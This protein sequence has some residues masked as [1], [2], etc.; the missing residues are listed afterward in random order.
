MKETTKE[1]TPEQI[2]KRLA[3]LP[4]EQRKAELQKIAEEMGAKP[5]E[6]QVTFS[7]EQFTRFMSG[8][9]EET[10]KV[11]AEKATE[12]E[13]KHP[14]VSRTEAEGMVDNEISKYL[15]QKNLR[16]KE[17]EII[18]KR[19]ASLIRSMQG[20]ARPGDYDKALELEVD[21]MKRHYGH[22]HR[23]MTLGD[24][25]TGGY[26]APE[27]W[28]TR[29]YQNLAVT[30]MAR[31]YCEL[32]DMTG[33]ELLR[34]P[35]L[36]GGLTA[37]TTGEGVAGTTSQITTDQF[38]LQ[39]KKITVISKPF[40]IELLEAGEPNLIELLTRDAV[41]AF[42]RKED[43]IVFNGTN[44]SEFTGLLEQTTNVVYLGGSST[45]G[46]TSY[47]NITHDD[48]F[49]LQN[50]LDE[51]YM[52]DEDTQGSGGVT[53]EAA[54]WLHRSVITELRKLKGN[55]Q[56]Y[57]DIQSMARE[58]RLGGFPFHRVKDLRAS[59]TADTKFGVFGNLKNVWV[60]YR[61]GIRT[62]MLRE[63]QVDGQNLATTSTM[64]LRF[65]EFWDHDVIDDE[66]LAIL[67]T[68]AS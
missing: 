42:G 47:V 10:K 65:N 68:A 19:F 45:S 41:R 44:D 13:R 35:K 17:N 63:G 46:N 26:L 62:D 55:D 67:S 9:T 12:V 18:G 49:N 5:A 59:T 3:E 53:G 28:E 24:D 36:T 51:E 31:K 48:I 25:T 57:W 33:R 32:I 58:N 7:E 22:E 66:S 34:L 6:P 23:A 30:G 61:P 56:Y 20:T 60:G 4:L 15:R 8:L 37:Y 50:E 38:S 40:S 2:Q 29:V 52:P 39:P 64:S 27:L 21:H 16:Q 54:Y 1:L 14:G 11:V 43:A